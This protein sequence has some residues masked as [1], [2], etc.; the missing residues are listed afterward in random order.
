MPFL[1]R[2]RE[3]AARPRLPRCA[4]LESYFLT[5]R[6]LWKCRGCKKQFSVKVG[7]TFEDSPI[8]LDKWMAAVWMLVNAKNGVSS[9]EI[10]RA[11]AVSQPCAWFMAH[12]I[13]PALQGDPTIVGKRLTYEHLR[14]A[15]SPA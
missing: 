3:V 13:R 2:Q 4:S 9:Y 12:R 15:E 14:G 7:T 6:R 10:S 1:R 5:T 11:I 8:P